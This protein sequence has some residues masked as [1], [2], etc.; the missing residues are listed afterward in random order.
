MS[1]DLLLA[2]AQTGDPR[3]RDALADALYAALGDYFRRRCQGSA[4]EVEDLIQATIVALLP[5]IDSFAAEHPTGFERV[6][7]ITA[8]RVFFTKYRSWQRERGRRADRIPVVIAP[9]TSPSARAA[10]HQVL[11]VLVGVISELDSNDQRAIGSWVD[12]T[13]WRD[14]TKREGV[15]RS[16]LRGRVRRALT[17]IREGV[18]RVDPALLSESTVNPTP[19]RLDETHLP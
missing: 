16:T 13:G 7:F 5:R 9:D 6:A 15:A 2:A 8:K 4:L 10:H 12:E 1:L 17:R 19:D 3:A 11:E 18:R 14:L